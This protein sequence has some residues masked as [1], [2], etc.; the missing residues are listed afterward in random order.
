M[1]GSP[2]LLVLDEPN[3]NLDEAGE[4]ALDR[5]LQAAKKRGQTV[6]IVS[7]RPIAIRNCDLMLV[8]QGGQVSLYGPREQVMAKL[9]VAAGVPPPQK[10][11]GAASVATDV[12]A[13]TGAAKVAQ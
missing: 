3:A 6:L 13:D 2:P 12:A 7:H 4:L 1:Y 8:M 9:A 10:S 11:A 5:A